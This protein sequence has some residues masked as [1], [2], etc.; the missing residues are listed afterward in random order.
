LQLEKTTGGRGKRF[1][2]QYGHVAKKIK[3]KCFWDR[4]PVLF[5][6]WDTR[7][8]PRGEAET[9]YASVCHK[10][11]SG[12]GKMKK[13]AFPSNGLSFK[14][15]LMKQGEGGKR[16]DGKGKDENNKG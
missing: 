7:C 5:P 12:Q 15:D 11:T 1:G 8:H 16:I 2:G 14:I 9:D 3:K 4:V 13:G 6:R 10:E